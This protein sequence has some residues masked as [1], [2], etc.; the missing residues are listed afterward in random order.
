MGFNNEGSQAVAMRLEETDI[1]PILGMNIGKSKVVPLEE[2]E[3]DYELSFR[4]LYD[5]GRYFV[6]NVSSPNTPG[7]RDLQKYEPLAELLGHLQE[8][9][10]Q[11]AR[12][13]NVHPRPMLVK[14]APDLTDSE[15]DAIL[16]VVDEKEIDGVIATNTTTR[17]EGLETPGQDELGPGGVSGRPLTERS[18]D[19]I[20]EIYRKTGGEVPIIGVGGIFSAGDALRAIK[21]GAS[22]V[23]VWT[24]FV[25]E[26]PGLPSRINDGLEQACQ[27]NGWDSIS[28][29]V[30][31]EA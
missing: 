22:L 9:N 26:G 8:I 4:R 30:G 17:R 2:A 18:R 25:Y 20:R 10:G 6:V 24:G 5:F 7:L 14:I 29:A 23:Q 21:A 1:E 3:R 15:L 27:R 19:M 12:R 16:R 28:E 13:R 11:L 31:L